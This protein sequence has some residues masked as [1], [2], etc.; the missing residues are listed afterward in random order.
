MVVA[1]SLMPATNMP[2]G[3][4]AREK[5]TNEEFVLKFSEDPGSGPSLPDAALKPPTCPVKLSTKNHSNAPRG[6]GLIPGPPLAQAV[7]RAARKAEASV[8]SLDLT[9]YFGTTFKPASSLLPTSLSP[10][11][12]TTSPL[13]R[14]LSLFPDFGLVR[15]FLLAEW[16]PPAL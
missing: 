12:M 7:A 9:E 15:G 5:R 8:H 4:T 11:R 10:Q 14:N 13:R 16:C 1:S 6:G 2:L 3:S